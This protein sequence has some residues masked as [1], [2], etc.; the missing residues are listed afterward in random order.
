MHKVAPQGEKRCAL[1]LVHIA[2]AADC[3]QVLGIKKAALLGQDTPWNR[4]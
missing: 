2:D 4:F 1:P 3:C